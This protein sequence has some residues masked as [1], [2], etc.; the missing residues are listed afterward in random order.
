MCWADVVGAARVGGGG[1]AGPHM[2]AAGRWLYGGLGTQLLWLIRGYHA[3][4]WGGR[5]WVVERGRAG[6]VEGGRVGM[7]R[8]RG[9]RGPRKVFV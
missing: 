6:S 5:G 8:P 7:R 2:G 3:H 4:A 9:M 1:L